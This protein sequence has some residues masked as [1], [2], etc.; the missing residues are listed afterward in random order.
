MNQAS[1]GTVA[2]FLSA[3]GA[4]SQR[5]VTKTTRTEEGS[6]VDKRIREETSTTIEPLAASASSTG[7][8]LT[9]QG[10]SIVTDDR[11]NSVTLI[12]EPSLV[13]LATSLTRQLDLRQRQV[14]VN[15]KVIDVNLNNISSF[16]SSFSFGVGDDAFVASDGGTAS[17][18]FGELAPAVSD[19][20]NR[21]E[22]TVDGSLSR[23]IIDNPYSRVPLGVNFDQLTNVQSAP[24]QGIQIINNATGQVVGEIPVSGSTYSSSPTLTSDGLRAIRSIAGGTPG[25][26]RFN[27]DNGNGVYDPT[28]SIPADG[29]IP[30][31]LGTI[32]QVLPAVIQYPNDFL[33]RLRAQITNGNAK[34]LTDPTLTVQEGNTA[35]VALTQDV[36]AGTTVTTVPISTDQ[37]QIVRS[38]RLEPVG[39]TLNLKVDRIDDNGFI[40]LSISPSVSAVSGF[41]TDPTSSQSAVLTSRRTLN[42]GSIRLRDGQT[43]IIAGVIQDQD[44]ETVSKWPILGD[45]PILGALFRNTNSNKQ[46]NEVV[47]VVTPQILDDSDTSS[48][49]YGYTPSPDVQRVLDRPGQ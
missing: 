23:P 13:E 18:N 48:F 49:G 28:D 26:L 17:A 35:A 8:P 40:T 9:L 11:L 46:R 10:L 15:V 2:A 5:V 12:G 44:R 36:F 41:Y 37:N 31:S 38:P 39:L 20:T 34:I 1:A 43:L 25:S 6:G 29:F 21:S 33:L 45:L 27:D 24:G 30:A 32:S 3:Q 22:G 14:A 42:S 7:A 19:P 47:I 16:T 4:E